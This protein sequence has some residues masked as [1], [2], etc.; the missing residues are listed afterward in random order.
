MYLFNLNSVSDDKWC[1]DVRFNELCENFV[2][3]RLLIDDCERCA[4]EDLGDVATEIAETHK[5]TNVSDFVN[6]AQ[7]VKLTLDDIADHIFDYAYDFSC[8]I[9]GWHDAIADICLH[10]FD[11]AESICAIIDCTYESVLE[12]LD[13]AVCAAYRDKAEALATEWHD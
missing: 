6:A 9:G 10:G 11:N 5:I 3:F 1:N 13:C 12:V 8:N 2:E 7:S 4:I